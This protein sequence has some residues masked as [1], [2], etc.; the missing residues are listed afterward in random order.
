MFPVFTRIARGYY[1]TKL[2]DIL[3]QISQSW[4]AVSV[5][6]A[7]RC[8]YPQWPVPT[9]LLMHSGLFAGIIQ[10]FYL[11]CFC[12][13]HV[14][15]FQYTWHTFRDL[16]LVVFLTNESSQSPQ[17]HV[18][19]ITHW[20]RILF[21]INTICQTFWDQRMQYVVPFTQEPEIYREYPSESKVIYE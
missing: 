1:L 8:G 9:A 16:F 3:T 20:D 11:L 4:P 19:H 17:Y 2:A 14:Y 6:P 10:S 5:L 18:Q 15:F 13:F 7:H 21:L 12:D